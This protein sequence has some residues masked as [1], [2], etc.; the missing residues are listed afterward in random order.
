MN[1]KTALV[2]L[3]VMIVALSYCLNSFRAQ[4]GNLVLYG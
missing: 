2:N 3:Q 4:Y 1:P